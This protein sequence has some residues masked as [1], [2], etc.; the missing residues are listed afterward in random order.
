MYAYKGNTRTECKHLEDCWHGWGEQRG[1]GSGKD[2]ASSMRINVKKESP[3]T[4][5]S[6]EAWAR[7][8]DENTKWII[9][10]VEL[11]NARLSVYLDGQPKAHVNE[12]SSSGS[13]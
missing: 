7:C 6:F 2:D 10:Y 1:Y 8:G 12:F 5:F 11:Q 3:F 13:S 4:S 9:E